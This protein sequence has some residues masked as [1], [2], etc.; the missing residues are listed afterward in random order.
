M[1]A[2]LG[3]ITGVNRKSTGEGTTVA[4][5]GHTPPLM[6]DPASLEIKFKAACVLPQRDGVPEWLKDQVLTLER[7]VVDVREIGNAGDS[8]VLTPAESD[9]WLAP[10][11]VTP[12]IA[13]GEVPRS[14]DVRLLWWKDEKLPEYTVRANGRTFSGQFTKEGNL[15]SARVDTAT[16]F[17]SPPRLPVTFEVTCEKLKAECAVLPGGEPF[18]RKLLHAGSQKYRIQ[19]AWFSAGITGRS[20]AGGIESLRE[21]GRGVDHFG[22]PG[23]AISYP[24]E[25][26]GH[27]DRVGTGGWGWHE[28]TR[29]TGTTC[30][31]ARREGGAVRLELEALIDEGQ[32]LRT[33]A[34]Y[35]LYDHLPLLLLERSFQFHKGKGPDKDKEK[36][37][38]PK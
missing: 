38:K 34:L 8:I 1:Q 20:H 25:Y 35:T 28:K 11:T 7:Q 18:A 31:G 14:L 26:A 29:E 15:G 16:F 19:N 13:S 33:T 37:E 12:D 10:L 36:D 30:A 27:S 22:G 6:G 5:N 24:C 3:K 32:N 17:T 23:N 4:G 21:Q 9:Q 2:L